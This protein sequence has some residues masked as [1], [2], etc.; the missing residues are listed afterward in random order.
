M[1]RR[2]AALVLCLVA[3]ASGA[4][5]VHG[6]VDVFTAP[7]VA[8]AWAVQRGSDEATTVVVIRVAVD[9]ARFQA[10]SVAGRDPFTRD[11]KVWM[12]RTPIAGKADVRL[13][14]AGFG[15]FPRTELRLFGP[16]AKPELEVYYLGVPDT[17]PE[18]NDR[19]KLDAYLDS[20]VA[21]P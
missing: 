2:L 3:T 19:A 7:G 1:K 6:K 14:R 17:T 10:I 13:A 5:E 16:G 9:P 18:F 8:L 20:R 4:A 12:A 15:D 11:E 21:K